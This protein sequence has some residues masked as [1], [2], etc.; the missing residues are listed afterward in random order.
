MLRY[1]IID[2]YIGK[3][4]CDS[5]GVYHLTN[6][7]SQKVLKELLSKGNKFIVS[8]EYERPKAKKSSKKDDKSE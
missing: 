1:K 6:N 5:S 3:C 8:E 2:S 7:L 4:H